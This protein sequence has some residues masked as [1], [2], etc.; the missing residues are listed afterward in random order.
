MKYTIWLSLGIYSTNKALACTFSLIKC[1]FISTFLVWEWR[2]KLLARY[3]TFTLSH[4]MTKYCGII[5]FSSIST[6][7][8]HDS[9]TM[10][11]AKGLNSVS[12]HKWDIILS[13]LRLMRLENAPVYAIATYASHIILTRCLIN[14]IISIYTQSLATV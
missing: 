3:S 14:I 5:T 11:W 1:K 6:F 12:I 9:F 13:S 2:T 10:V 7:W 8:I 4:K